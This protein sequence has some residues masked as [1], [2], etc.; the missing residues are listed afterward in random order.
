MV[1]DF[2][3][4]SC[5]NY[6]ITAV[7][8]KILSLFFLLVKERHIFHPGHPHPHAITDSPNDDLGESVMAGECS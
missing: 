3:D 2:N 1:E 6:C 8:L 7:L 5:I 4:K